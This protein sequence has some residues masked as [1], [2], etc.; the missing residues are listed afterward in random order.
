MCI[1]DSP[2]IDGRRGMASVFDGIDDPD[3][4]AT[5]LNLQ[6]VKQVNEGTVWLRY[7]FRK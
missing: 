7:T 6:S 1:R 4:P 5:L 3:R 2:G